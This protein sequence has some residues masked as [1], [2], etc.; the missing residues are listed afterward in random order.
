MWRIAIQKKHL[1]R[2]VSADMNENKE[3]ITH[4]DEL[5]TIHISEDV[6]GAIAASAAAEIE[7]VS[8][9][10]GSAMGKKNPNRGVKISLQDDQA[11]VD[12]YVMIRYGQPIP[13]VAEKIQAAV[14]AVNVHVGGI[15]FE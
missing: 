5:G 15:S 10:M 13:E 14:Q 12:V 8:S 7:G 11:V 4:P 1:F 3:Y 6:L 2:G 9:L